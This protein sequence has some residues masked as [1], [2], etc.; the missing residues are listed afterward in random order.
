MQ[1]LINSIV[2]H[3]KTVLVVFGVLLIIFAFLATRVRVNYNL[4][5][6]LPDDQPSVLAIDKLDEEF[7]MT[8]PNARVVFP[9]DSIREGLIG[10][11]KLE[12]TEGVTQVLWL[13][14]SMDLAVPLEMADKKLTEIFY[15]DGMA[16]YQVS[17]DEAMAKD[18]LSRIYDL[19][20]EVKV[21]G[22]LVD[23]A[24]AQTAEIGRAHV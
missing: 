21:S 24:T 18:V 7:S 11:Q 17:A 5:D 1:R 13:D 10:K 9:V 16:L 20:P 19:D 14:D 23:L 6:Y 3:R 4:Q 22:E 12:E 2:K 8:L 15:R